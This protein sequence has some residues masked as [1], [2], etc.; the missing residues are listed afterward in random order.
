MLTFIEKEKHMSNIAIRSAS[1]LTVMGLSLGVA[2]VGA[3]LAS[4]TPPSDPAPTTAPVPTSNIDFSKKGSL[5]LSKRIIEPGTEGET[6]TGNETDVANSTLRGITFELYLVK[7]I[8]NADDWKAA[9]ELGK[10][11]ANG[12]EATNLVASKTTD[13]NG[14][15]DFGT[16]PLGLY[17]LVE[18]ESNNPSVTK[19]DDA[20]IYLPMTN[21]ANQNTWNYDVHVYPKNQFDPQETNIEK[22]VDDAQKNIGD[23]VTYTLNS[24]IPDV[25]VNDVTWYQITDQL[26]A[27]IL[28]TDEATVSVA[29]AGAVAEA[30]ADYVV[31]NENGLIKVSF[32]A[33]GVDKLTAAKKANADARVT[34]T[35][36]AEVSK[37]ADGH[38]PNKALLYHNN[39]TVNSDVK[40]NPEDPHN[41]PKDPEDPPKESNEVHSYWANIELNKVDDKDNAL[42]GAEFE[43]YRCSVD[44]VLEG[45]A[46]AVDHDNNPET[47][48]QTTLV[49]GDDGKAT[50]YGLKVTDFENNVPV[51]PTAYCLV[52]T[53]AP[54]GFSLLPE[55]VPVTL[56][57]AETHGE[58]VSIT[59]VAEVANLPETRGSLP[60]TGGMGIGFLVA[61]GALIVAVGAYTAQRFGK[62]A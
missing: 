30:G 36:V 33:A 27:E 38:A 53:K 10:D 1:A 18:V 56:A 14:Y 61:L 5:S 62:S 48:L 31:F 4:A 37:V 6:A 22:K 55:P 41:P 43:L 16:L 44:G 15:I 46:L 39:P 26:D 13:A 7:A 25:T 45:D 12:V 40:P 35:I 32:T 23:D 59:K 49:T 9:V 28:K 19:A 3:P 17:K 47:P 24:A 21:P 54:E 52:E 2:L 29:I 42:K 60:L 51:D 20:L 58:T 50:F 8:N 34:T 11:G 57:Q